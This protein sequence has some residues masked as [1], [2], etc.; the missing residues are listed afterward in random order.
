M[1]LLDNYEPKE[2]W[3][4]FEEF[5]KIPHGSGNIKEIS[6]YVVKFAKDRDLKYRQDEV[7]NVVI[8]KN[9][10]EGYESSESVILQGH[11]DMVAVKDEDVNKDLEKEPIELEIVHADDT[12]DSEGIKGEFKHDEWVTAKGT[13]L[14]G[15]DGMAVAYMLAILDSNEIKHPPLECVFTIDEEIGMIGATELDVS[16]LK[17]K[18][19]LNADSQHEGK[20]VVGC[21]GGVIVEGS[22]PINKEPITPYVIEFRIDGLTG[23]HSGT[24]IDQYRMN[25]LVAMGRILLKCFQNVGMRIITVDGGVAD[26]AI[27][28][29]AEAA[30]VVLEENREETVKII[31]ETFEEIKAEYKNTDPN[32]NLTINEVGEQDVRALGDG[33]TLATIIALSNMPNGIQRY[34][35]KMKSVETSLNLGVVRTED[36]RVTFTFLVRSTKETAKWNVVEQIRAL[37]E[38]F[39][40]EIK[41]YGKYNGWEPI[42]NSKITKVMTESFKNLFGKEPKVGTVHAGLECGIFCDKIEGLDVIS[43]GPQVDDIHTT[44]EKASILSAQRCWELILKTLE[45]L[46]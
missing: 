8:F 45:E 37:T 15:D 32:A 35:A 40:G 43:F 34:D 46:K 36:D 7:G 1:G 31:K 33:S 13:T 17:G 23:G 26:N 16:D 12:S 18:I 42:E 44:D 27:P 39:G 5:S 3:K 20:F 9:G 22:L 30:V 2:V 28:T 11:I 21:A 19:L 14:G 24:A 41:T 6:D 4:F 25:G 10:T 29:E 38:I